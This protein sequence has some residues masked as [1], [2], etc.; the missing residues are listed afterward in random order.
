MEDWKK[1]YQEHLITMEEAAKLVKSDDSLWLGHSIGIPYDFLNELNKRRDDLW[2]VRIM[3]NLATYPYDMLFDPESIEHF[4]IMSMFLGPLERMSSEMG[5]AEVHSVPYEYMTRVVCDTYH[6]NV[7]CTE[8]CPPDENGFINIS[9]LGAP[10]NM[11]KLRHPTKKLKIGVVNKHQYAAQG[12]FE[13][14]N[15]PVNMF[16]YFVEVDHE[17]SYQ[18]VSEP[19]PV[20]KTIASYVMEYIKDG[21]SVQ[22]GMGGLGEQITKELY[23]KKDIKVFTEISVDSMVPLAE[24]GAISSVTT[25][26]CYGSPVIYEFLGTS[27]LVT[28]KNLNTMLDPY[29]IGLNDNMVAICSTLMVDLTGQACSEAQGLKEYSGVGGSFAYLYGATRSKGGRSFLC[30]RS[31]YKDKEGNRKSSVVPWLPEGSVVT[32]PRYIHMYI[33]S[34]HG[35]ADVFLKSIKDRIKALIKIAH[36]DYR[37]ELKE[38]IISSGQIKSEDFDN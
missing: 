17:L 37:D 13:D 6:A 36:P 24:S 11:E 38:K 29:C 7:I 30:L 4:R 35:V 16:D 9:I 15:V 31:T 1:Y 21:D 34:E 28:T 20:D 12:V 10:S 3:Y 19:T 8:I 25:A 23:S 22:I 32:S 33:V 27:K 26:G 14:F 18:P 5:I 2:N